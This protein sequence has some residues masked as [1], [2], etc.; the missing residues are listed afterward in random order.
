MSHLAGYAYD[1]L[2][3]LRPEQVTFLQDRPKAELHAHLNGCIP[4][5]LLKEMAAE[6]L[7]SRS[8]DDPP[9]SD[10]VREGI[11]RLQNG[12]SLNELHDFFGLFPAIY[13]LTSNPDNL[14][15]AARAVLQ[16]FLDPTPEAPPQAAYM[17]L[18]ST[19][20]ETPAMSRLKYIQTVLDEVEKY[21]SERCALIVSLD[22]RMKPEVVEE[23]VENAIKLKQEGRRVVA[24]DLCGDPTAGDMNTIEKYFHRAKAA[25]L[26]VTLHIAETKA[27]TLDDTL[28]LL[29]FAPDRL[30]HATFLGSKE[31]DFVRNSKICVE[32][33]LTSNLLCKTVE[34]LEDHHIQHYLKYDHPV[35]ICTDD[36]LAFRNTLVAEY[37]L[38]M[39]A[40]PLGLGLTEAEITRVAE[41]GM[42]SRFKQTP[43]PN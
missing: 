1:A 16:Q 8:S 24:V 12:A 23:C 17:E 35:C 27:N 37:A 14:G 39:A 42:Q 21:P 20:R 32:I 36:T 10:D 30:G 6:R 15:R 4:I 29:S 7:A 33:C 3:S 11:E 31:Q 38:L 34:K 5:S 40:A 18:R 41:M 28:K 22:R 26:G 9:F 13:S 43:L 19:P 2:Q 25:G